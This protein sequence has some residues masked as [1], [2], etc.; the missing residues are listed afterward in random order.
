MKILNTLTLKNLKLNRKRT[1]VTI[2]GISL[3]VAL[4]CAITTFAVS[5]QNSMIERETKTN[6]NY[7][8]H[9][10]NVSKENKKYLENNAKIEK[11][12]ISQEIG[13]AVLDDSKNENK[14]YA[15]IEGYDDALLQNGGIILIEGRLPENENEIVIPEHVIQNGKINLDV[16]E[17]IELNI[18]NRYKGEY[19]LNQS[20]P[21]YTEQ[22][23]LDRK[24]SG[25]EDDLEQE[26][27]VGNMKRTYTIVGI[28]ERLNSESYSAPGYTMITKLEQIDETKN[29]NAS[30]VL[31]DPAE[32]YNFEKYLKNDLKIN[33]TNISK[34]AE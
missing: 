30:I 23:R 15:Y 14:P 3:S 12:E 33:E 4:I 32:T 10:Q 16:G 18:G 26:N 28:M 5:F 27:F 7:H 24:E 34:V 19:I 11:L 2:I 20:N 25:I 8:I 17:T 13:Y 29:I 1:I 31:K 9:V 22:D 6:G 21:Y